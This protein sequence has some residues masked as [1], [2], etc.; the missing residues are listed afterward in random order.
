MTRRRLLIPLVALLGLVPAKRTSAQ[1][2]EFGSA[3]LQSVGEVS[4]LIPASP[5]LMSI[6]PA[7]SGLADTRTA[8][9]L[10]YRQPFGLSELE[11]LT[12]AAAHQLGRWRAGGTITRSGEAGLYQE[13]R[14]TGAIA[15][16][17]L[18]RLAVGASLMYTSA[19]FGDNLSRYAGAFGTLSVAA[20]PWPSLHLAAALHSITLDRVYENDPSDPVVELSAAW[21]AGEEVALG[22][23]WRRT[24]EGDHRFGLGQVLSLSDNVEFLA[25]LR[26]DPVRYALGGRFRYRGGALVYTY[27][28]HPELGGTHAIGLAWSR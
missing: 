7:L 8:L 19:E 15:M 17:P 18:R 23:L 1:D 11:D 3:M 26:F 10:S 21:T 12:L 20:R 16:A 25:G 6:H 24:R 28:G 22:A 4:A 2:Y 27:E 14:L 13:Y 5:G 9:E